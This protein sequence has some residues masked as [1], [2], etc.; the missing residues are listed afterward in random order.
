MIET[1]GENMTVY[2][3]V[4]KL[5]DSCP[6]KEGLLSLEDFHK[7][8][9]IEDIDCRFSDENI[10][11]GAAS[12]IS[13]VFLCTIMGEKE[14]TDWALA[15]SFADLYD[16]RVCAKYIA[17]AYIKG[18]CPKR[19]DNIFGYKDILSDKEAF[20]IIERIFDKKKRLL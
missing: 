10:T 8:G 19:T 16:C 1:Y 14:V 13:T 11:K 4:M 2:D 5:S 7:R 18:I 20:D 3:F 17:N 9:I 15:S 6:K 12:R